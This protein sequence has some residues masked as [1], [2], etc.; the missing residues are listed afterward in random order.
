MEVR[1]PVSHWWRLPSGAAVCDESLLKYPMGHTC[2]IH[3]LII[4]SGDSA[5]AV[6]QKKLPTDIVTAASSLGYYSVEAKC[7]WYILL[8]FVKRSVL[9]L[10]IGMS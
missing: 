5:G 2:L 9:C 1:L 4:E 8:I 3:N 10:L 6:C 7:I